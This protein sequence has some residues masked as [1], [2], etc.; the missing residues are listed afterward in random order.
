MPS[1]PTSPLESSAPTLSKCEQAPYKS[2]HIRALCVRAFSSSPGLPTVPSPPFPRR[3]L[4]CPVLLIRRRVALA[5]VSGS[6][7]PSRQS[8]PPRRARRLGLPKK[9]E[10]SLQ[11]ALVWQS[12]STG[13][14]DWTKRSS[15]SSDCGRQRRPPQLP[16][17]LREPVRGR[18]RGRRHQEIG[19]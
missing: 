15:G 13:P 14:G 6:S 8:F 2:E 17:L 12:Q 1:N 18:D 3:P 10:M 19:G 5:P 11:S 7:L 4:T 16:L 9:S